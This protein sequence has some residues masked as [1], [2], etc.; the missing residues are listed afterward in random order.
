M[1]MRANRLNLGDTGG[2]QQT[3]GVASGVLTPLPPDMQG[4]TVANALAES[5][6][7][8]GQLAGSI[9]QVQ[10]RE[11]RA[12][13]M[14]DRKVE[15]FDRGA[16]V[17]AAAGT[18]AELLPQIADRKL[19]AAVDDSELGNY[20]GDL[21]ASRS[22]GQSKAW[23]DEYDK[24]LRGRLLDAFGRQRAGIREEAKGEAVDTAKWRAIG[25]GSSP[26]IM[27]AAETLKTTFNMGDHDAYAATALPA[28][29]LAA[30]QGD[31]DK[32]DAAVLALGDRFPGEVSEAQAKLDAN[33]V[34]NEKVLQNGAESDFAGWYEKDPLN[35]P[36]ATVAIEKLNQANMSPQ[37][38]GTWRRR[39]EEEQGKMVARS[40][41]AAEDGI[42]TALS[43]GDTGTARSLVEQYGEKFGGEWKLNA[44]TRVD[45]YEAG[46]IEKQSK[47]AEKAWRTNVAGRSMDVSMQA[48]EHGV[49]GLS[50]LPAEF[51]VQL[52]DG[53]TAK[54]SKKDVVD[55][56]RPQVF[57]AFDQKFKDPQEALAN[58]VRWLSAN[59]VEAPE[60][61]ARMNAGAVGATVDAL[62][63]PERAKSAIGGFTLY[64]HLNANNPALARQ[65]VGEQARE[66]YDM[67]EGLL[68][69]SRNVVGGQMVDGNPA[70]ALLAA[71]R[72]MADPMYPQHRARAD[73]A[74]DAHKTGQQSSLEEAASELGGVTADV[75]DT[76]RREARPLIIGG[77]TP[78]EALATVVAR[79]KPG[80]VVVGGDNN[81][82]PINTNFEGFTDQFRSLLPKYSKAVLDKY[83]AEDG[84][85]QGYDRADLSLNLDPRNGQFYI[86]DATGQPVRTS[87]GIRSIIFDRAGLEKAAEQAIKEG[88]LDQ[89]RRDKQGNSADLFKAVPRSPASRR[90]LD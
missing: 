81:R 26:E 18:Y 6:G 44:Q 28:L 39:I 15:Q 13:E 3:V 4:S 57:A 75:L 14:E 80:V 7:L 60:W 65:M 53:K 25:A 29:R 20:V 30:E 89:A 47:D 24:Q 69:G 56:V 45:R 63:D 48:F 42:G 10:A 1:M 17:K 64:R 35:L 77:K 66:L 16:A 33:R 27:D 8:F 71:S 90:I 55:S 43:S 79:Y 32:F 38:K 19:I 82:R 12:R 68:S 37:D 52:P 88:I 11:Q 72:I 40:R 85:A 22:G 54:M 74:L 84:K 9:A 62:S 67:T 87:K 41:Q 59:G 31:Q 2:I 5:L 51:E 83:H 70:S 58:K 36:P 23:Q 21:I 50:D 76:L 49:P 46:V 61:T 73:A 86:V 34:R 78:Q